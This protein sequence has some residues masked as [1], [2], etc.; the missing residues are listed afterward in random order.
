M[1]SSEVSRRSVLGAALALAGCGFRPVYGPGSK[2]AGLMGKV[3]YQSPANGNEFDLVT[4]LEERFGRADAPFWS[5]GYDLVVGQDS[6][7]ASHATRNQITGK[8]RFRLAP[9][10]GGAAAVTGEVSAFAAYTEALATAADT[11][12]Q[13]SN[14]TAAADARRRLMVM[15]ADRVVEAIIAGIAGEPA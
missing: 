1:W 6:F 5:L 2:A 15:L 8:V 12:A 7:S 4:R 9:V 13:L 14:D 10:S 11:G 3:G